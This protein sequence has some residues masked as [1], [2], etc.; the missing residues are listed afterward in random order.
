MS[1]PV[2]VLA[3]TLDEATAAL[4][5]VHPLMSGDPRWRDL[6]PARGGD[7]G[8]T[9]KRYLTR[10]RPQQFQH[11]VFAS[12]RGAG[13]STELFRLAHDVA[14]RFFCL[15]LEANVEMDPNT[16]EMEDLLLVLAR[17]VE[18]KL[19]EAGHPLDA[20]ALERVN[21]W[22]RQVIETTEVGREYTGSVETT[23]KGGFEI[24]FLTSV[25]A[26]V[27]A[28]FK[29]ESKHR[30]EV[31]D[32]LRQYP[33][34]LMESV[35]LLLDAANAALGG[36]RQLL[37]IIDNL[38]RYNPK[39]IDELLVRGGDR[40]RELRAHLILTPPISL[41][42]RPETGALADYFRVEIMPS[43]RL[44]GPTD[45]PRALNGQGPTL[46]LEA[47][48]KRIDLD[49]LVPEPAVRDRIVLASGGSIRELLEVTADAT[50]VADGEH[51]AAPDVE[52]ALRRR[53]DRM[54][55]NIN[56]NGW[57]D[58]LVHIA[59]TG[60]ISNEDSYLL[61]LHHRLAFKYNEEGW[62]GVHPLV[63]D[64]PEFADAL[65]RREKSEARVHVG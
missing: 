39:V 21:G 56:F 46:L 2:P 51:L 20:K 6:S 58:T 45:P 35:N 26:K 43:V 18:E 24:P 13:K 50:L 53:R 44:R 7:V 59:R 29:V 40:F 22:F 8:R 48:G 30:S 63:Y 55:D 64:I 34:T 41:V 4:D 32:V 62:Y 12:H 57:L 25:L 42:Y 5:F 52:R 38:D 36:R 1:Q 65:A 23:A 47:L 11:V 28:L 17:A 16:I 9:V 3:T 60:Q 49:A 54:R 14:D 10:A 61:V 37:V 31:K 27:N 33:G 19:R 15:Y